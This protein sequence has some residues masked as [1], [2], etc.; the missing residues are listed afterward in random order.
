MRELANRRLSENLKQSVK[1]LTLVFNDFFIL[2]LIF[3]FGA[4]M[5]WYAQAMRVIPNNL[6]FYKPLVGFIMWLPLLAGRLVTLLKEADMQ[7]LFT[8]DEQMGRGAFGAGLGHERM[9]ADGT[10][11]RS[12]YGGH[13]S[14]MGCNRTCSRDVSQLAHRRAAPADLY[15]KDEISDSFGFF[16]PPV[17]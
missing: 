8:Q 4:L 7:F 12:I 17:P 9:A 11:R 16:R 5:F 14:G 13:Q 15:G 10:P 6:W 2:A 3:L 1:Y